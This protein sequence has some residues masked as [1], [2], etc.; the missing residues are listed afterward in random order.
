MTSNDRGK[1]L[2]FLLSLAIPVAP[3]ALL[4]VDPLLAQS[5]VSPLPA[6][7]PTNATG[8]DATGIK[9][10]SD[11]AATLR[12]NGSSSMATI[13]QTLERQFE[14]KFPDINVDSAYD[15]TDAALKALL[16]EEI[17]L[18]AIGRPL[19]EAEQAQGL[20]AVPVTRNKIAIIVAKDNPFTGS[21]TIDQFAKIFRGEITDWAEVGGPDG[22]IRFVDRPA[23]SDTRQAF[24]TYPVFQS[25]P[26]EAGASAV[27][28]SEDATAAVISE[29]GKNGI[30][31]AIVDQVVNNP[32]V[33]IVSMHK[34]LPTDARY[35]FSQPLLYVYRGSD[36][37]P[38][39][40]SFLD[41]A[42]AP[43]NQQIVESARAASVAVSPSPSAPGSPDAASD[44][45]SPTVT[46]V[47]PE[48]SPAAPSLSA[49]E[50]TPEPAVS[51]V[52]APAT[53]EPAVTETVP[54]WPWWLSIPLLGGL[55]WWLLKE[56]GGDLP[57]SVASAPVL[58]KSRLVLTP[59]NCRD[60]Y[61]YW[62]VP[63]ATKHD[64][65]AQGGQK[66]MV[67]LYDVTDVDDMD[68]QTPHSMKQF[69][70]DELA[71]DLH[72]PIPV[73]N[74]DYV[75]EL[76]Y[77][78]QDGRWLKIVR[79]AHVRIPACEPILS[80]STIQEPVGQ[81]VQELSRTQ[82]SADSIPSPVASGATDTA[83]TAVE[84]HSL[85]QAVNPG[86]AVAS[87]Y[88][89]TS[90]ADQ[91][92]DQLPARDEPTEASAATSSGDLVAAPTP[93]ERDCRI[94]LVPRNAH[95]AY[96]YW[97]VSEN[98]KQALR[99]QGGQRL[100]LRIHDVTNLDIDYEPPHNTLEYV[101]AEVEQDM[102][103]PIPASDRDYIAELG[104]V[105]SDSRWLRLI[106]SFHVR[107]P[108]DVS[109]V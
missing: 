54:W 13:N 96:V 93:L 19:T 16:A 73:D 12:I 83:I 41:Y 5:P 107:V 82:L 31:Y 18:A 57:A 7:E 23:T 85:Q 87:A 55:L 39:V 46:N 60:A 24:R 63:E 91:V 78:T 108:A 99:Q 105:T 81:P 77:L 79:S 25:A 44:A 95:T 71:Q 101:C 1:T 106:R 102:H 53:T 35:P 48:V 66:L 47:S 104:Y 38:S 11:G 21:L 109:S 4:A 100:M 59:R 76:G 50:A 8:A 61:A 67:R 69:D 98:Y 70:C 88:P 68:R 51:P 6:S 90:A 62:E 94:I 92:A 22:A 56:Q 49:V 40:Q 32:D 37:S 45:P 97:E 64:I 20:V 43:E 30:G 33:Q 72:I 103:V 10:T 84:G 29:L 74:R 26:F 9:A 34:T 2:A 89:L 42:I 14:T 15:G 75:A 65:R 80:T 28:L 27:S 52:I 86:I 3:A 58:Q 17:D 36:P